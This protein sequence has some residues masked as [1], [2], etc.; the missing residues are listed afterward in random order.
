M[1]KNIGIIDYGCGNIHSLSCALKN[2]GCNVS[3]ISNDLKNKNINGIFIPGVG[4]FDNAMNK[5]R[6]KNLDQVIYEYFKNDYLIVGICL[7]MQILVDTGVENS[8]T[9]GLKLIKGN[10]YKLKFKNN[11]KNI[12]I[13]WNKT[14]FTKKKLNQFDKEKFYYVHSY[15]VETHQDLSCCYST[16]NENKFISGLINQ[17]IYA[18][19][20]H[21]EKSGNVGLDLL[22]EV[23]KN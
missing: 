15:A 19:Q 4:S 18:F 14:Y 1:I 23:I 10:T 12:N 22:K 20:F 6:K 17:N 16:F 5:I 9:E 3:I 8:I 2:I 7:G 21:P 11:E 13:G